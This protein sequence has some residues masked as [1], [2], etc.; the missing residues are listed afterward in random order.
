MT[1][2]L[3]TGGAGFIGS[4]FT[5]MMLERH[6]DIS[7]VV[8]DLLTYAGN[9]DNLADLPPRFG[10][11]YAFVR[12]DIADPEAV[13]AAFC[14]HVIDTVVNFAAATHVDRSI[15]G[16]EDFVR[17]D[18]E[19][20]RV[21][22]EA[23]RTHGV[24]RFLQVSTDEVYGEVLQGAAKESDPLSPRNPYSA[25]K[26]A[27]ELMAQ[28]YFHTY[29]LPVVVTRGC[30][31]YGPYQYPEKFIPLFVTN[32]LQ[33]LPL[34]LYGDGRQVREWMHVL[35]HCSAI[36]TVLQKGEAGRVYNIGTGEH[37]E[38]IE[39]ARR[40]VAALGKPESLIQR[41]QDRPG[42]DRRYAVDATALRALGWQP[43]HSFEEA[44]AE[45]VRWYRDHPEWWQPLKSGEYLE[46]YQR[47]YGGQMA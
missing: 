25:S 43:E 29:G 6:P 4:N 13:E 21:L 26:A 38:N 16:A 34:P 15:L 23:A 42:H 5:R 19:G 24:E 31:T 27:G 12:G 10:A 32:A 9:L 47:Q 28:A 14:E 22:L 40:I 36:E 46:Y 3:I 33:D 20:T 17:T 37:R 11:R 41:V 44:L 2:L 1:T 30:N 18:V 7:V 8:Y 35:D 45:T 39:V